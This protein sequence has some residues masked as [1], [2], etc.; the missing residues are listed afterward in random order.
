M[1]RIRGKGGRERLVPVLP[2]AARAVEAYRALLPFPP[3]PA[4]PL[5]LGVA[6]RRRSTSGTCRR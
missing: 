1:L 6:R 4:A 2:V 3:D 5:F